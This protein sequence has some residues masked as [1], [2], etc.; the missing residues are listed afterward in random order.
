MK[1]QRINDQ[2]KMRVRPRSTKLSTLQI[3]VFGLKELSVSKKYRVRGAGSHMW[4]SH[5][6]FKLS[7]SYVR[8]IYVE[9]GYIISIGV[10]TMSE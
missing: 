7:S 3:Q 4:L 6:N 2:Q 8:R 9:Q 5:L 10:P 1:V